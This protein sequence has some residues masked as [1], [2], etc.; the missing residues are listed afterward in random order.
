[1]PSG[2]APLDQAVAEEGTRVVMKSIETSEIVLL[3]KLSSISV[4]PGMS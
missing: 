1:M 3:L 4:F 2:A